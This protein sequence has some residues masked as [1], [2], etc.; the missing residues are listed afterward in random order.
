MTLSGSV[1]GSATGGAWSTPAGGTFTPNA[2]TLTATWTPPAVFTGI[3][4]LTLTTTGMAPCSAVTSTV[5]ITVNPGPTANAGPPQT[6]CQGGSVTLS[7]TIGGSATGGTWTTPVGGTFTPDANTL[8]ATWT[9][10][11]AYSGNAVL[12]LTTMGSG[13]CPPVISTVTITVKIA[14][15]VSAGAPQTI[16][17][18]GSAILVGTVGGSA[19]GGTWST[20]V[21]GVFSPN[22][23]T[24]A[25]TWTPP[26][27]YTGTA[28][29]TLT[30]TGMGPCV[31]INSTVNIT[32]TPAPTANAGAP[33][34]ICQ[35]GN[36]SLSGT[37]GGSASGGTWTTLSGGVF[38]P[39]P[40]TLTATWT[41]PAAFSG[42]A[43]LTLTTT[44]MS[45]C[46]AVTSNVIITVKQTPTAN[47]GGPQNICQGGSA[48]LNG[49][50]GGS[51]TGGF[52]TTIAGGTFTPNANTLT[53]TWTPLPGFSGPATLTL[54]TTGMIPCSA[55]TSD[56]IITVKPTPT[57]NA[58]TAQTICQ[59]GSA[60]LSGLV[61]GSATGGTWSTPVG[62]TFSPNA[63]TLTTTWTPPA[64]YT[65]TATLTL[66]TTGMAPC[67]A[68]L[69]TV[70]ITV[71][72]G[73]TANA[74][75]PQ[76]ICQGGTVTLSGTIGGSATG[77][78]WSTP[79]GGTF[80]PDANTL[81]AT[82]TPP[83][84]YT[85]TAQLT[86]TTTGSGP[87]P[88]VISNVNIIVN[89]VP[90][91]NAQPVP[92]QS[93]CVGGVLPSPLN[94]TFTGG[95]GTPAYQWYSNTTSSTTGGT[96]IPGA[97]SSNYLPP[98][99]GS[100]GSFYFYVVITFSANGCN[101]VTSNSAEVIV[102]PDPT[103]TDPL[104]T[105]TLCQNSI[106]ADLVVSAAGGVGTFSYQW[107]SNTVNNNTTGTIIA[108]AIGVS[109]TP[110]TAAVGTKYYYC[111]ITQT[112]PG[113]GVSSN[114]STVIVNAGPTFTTQ[115]AP[116]AVCVGGTPTLLN[117]AY[118]NGAGI[119][120]YQWYSNTVNSYVG[121]TILAGENNP[122]YAPSSTIAGTT[123]Y[124]CVISFSSGGCSSINSNI[125]QVVIDA[126]PAISTQPIPTQDL[127]VG[128]VLPA[129][130]SVSYTGGTGIASYQW[131]SNT[132]A[133]TT[134]GT[135]IPGATSSTYLPPAFVTAGTYY[136]YVI[137]SLSGS[138][139][140][141]ATSSIA[142]VNVI[143]DPTVTN[144]LN[145]QSLCQNVAPS[146]LLVTASGGVGSYYYQWYSNTVN[147]NTTGTIIAGAITSSY[148]PPTTAVG[149]KYYYCVITQTGSGCGVSSNTATVIVNAGATI[150][151]QPSPSNVCAGGT[152]TLLNVAF[153]NGAG[154]PSFQWYSNSVNSYIGGTTLLG[155]TNANYQPSGTIAG[156]TFYFC[157]ISFSAGGG[158]GS[159]NSNIAQVDV[160][161]IPAVTS[162]PLDSI[163]SRNPFSYTITSDVSNCSFGWHRSV[164][165]GISNPV[166]NGVSA[167]INETLINTTGSD[168]NVIYKLWTNGPAPTLCTSDTLLLLV[169]VKD[170]AVSAGNDT[171]ISFGTRAHLVGLATGG[172]GNLQYSWTP[173]GQILSGQNARLAETINQ[174]SPSTFTLTVTDLNMAGCVLTDNVGVFLNGSALAASPTI[175]PSLVCP[176]GLTQLFSNPSGGSGTYTYSWSSVP[177][178]SPI[179]NSTLADPFVNPIVPTTYTV[180]VNDGFN[181]ASGS[182]SNTI[183]APPV[184]FNVTGGGQYCAGGSGLPI[185]L[186][187]SSLL[188]TYKLK[189]QSGT[190]VATVTGTGS[191]LTFG[192][193]TIAG[194]YTAEATSISS[195][196]CTSSMNGSASISIIP[197]PTAYTVTGGGS[198]PAGG[199]GVDIG[200][201]N[202]QTGVEY[203][204]SNGGPVL[205][206][207]Q[208]TGSAIS[209]G[210]QT[211]AGTYTVTAFTLTNPVCTVA[212]TGSVTVIINPWPTIYNVYGGG[213]VCADD[214][215]GKPVG[216]DGSDVGVTYQLK[217]DGNNIGGPVPGTGDSI[218]FGYFH[219]G[220][221][222]SVT[223]TNVLTGLTR[224][225]NGIATININPIPIAYVMGSYGDNC[226]GSEIMLNGSQTGAN[227][228]LRLNLNP[229]DTMAG[230]GTVLNFG[231][232]WQAG[233]YTIYAY[234]V[235]TGC[236]TIM[237][238]MIHLNPAPNVYNVRP[239]GVSCAGDTL[240]ITGSQIGIIY[241][242]QRDTYTNV[243]SPI[244]GTGFPI[245]FGPQTVA[246]IYS[247][248]AI[249][250]LTNCK[251]F[252]NGTANLN[253]LPGLFT[254]VPN[255][256]TCAGASIGLSGSQLGMK[257]IL[258]RD[259]LWLDTLNGTGSPLE[260]G[261]QTIPGIYTIVGY[262]TTTFKFCSNLMLGTTVLHPGPVL[263]AIIP[264]GFNCVGDSVGLA[265]SDI[266]VSYQ[267]ILNGNQNAGPPVAG[268][269]GPIWFGIQNYPGNYTI[270]GRNTTT[271]CSSIM[272]GTCILTPLPIAYNIIPQGD[273][274]AG[275]SI[276]LN[277]SQVG[278]NYILLRDN[279]PVMTLAGTGGIL[280]FGPQTISGTYIIRAYNVTPD[281]CYSLMTGTTVIYQGPLAY[282]VIPTGISCAGSTVGLSG[283]QIG[284]LYQLFR[285][286]IYNIGVPVPG[287]G[288]AISFGV[289]VQPGLYS[290]K[291][292]SQSSLCFSV[293]TGEATLLTLPSVYT[294]TPTGD[295][296]AHSSIGINGS[297]AGIHY[298]LFRDAIYPVATIN[299]NGGPVSFGLQT[300]SGV[301]TITAYNSTSDSCHASM[302]GSLTIHPNPSIFSIVPSGVVCGGNTV[303]LSFSETGVNYQLFRDNVVVDTLAGTGAFLDFGPQTFNGVYTILAINTI[304]N[305]WSAMTGS[306]TI[307]PSPTA[308]TMIP[309]G[310]TCEQVTIGL[311]GS[312]PGISYILKRDGIP[313]ETVSGTGSPILFTYVTTS[314]TYSITAHNTTSDTCTAGM[315]GSLVIHP[316]PL[317]YN[318]IP[319]GANCE[320][321][322]IGITGS[323]VGVD[324]ELFKNGLTTGTILT[325]TGN[326][327]SFSDQLAG[328]YTVKG[329]YALSPNCHSLMSGSVTVNAPPTV[330]AGA[331]DSV[332]HSATTFQLS[333][334]ASEYTTISWATSGDGFFTN[335]TALNP[336]YTI[337]VLDKDNGLVNLTILVNG[338]PECPG[339]TATDMMT[340]IIDP[341]PIAN[342]GPDYDLCQGQIV[343]L[344]G[345]AQHYSTVQWT[346]TGDGLFSNNAILNPTY[347][348]G[349]GD[350]LA[351]T[352]KLIL[353]ANGSLTCHAEI[354]RDTLS[355]SIF[356]LPTATISESA[357]ICEA[358]TASVVVNLTGTP[359]WSIT[360]TD[361]VK[362]V[363]VSPIG[364]SPFILQVNPSVTT[365][366]SLTALSDDH[367]NGISFTGTAIIFVHP[368]PLVYQVTVTN[369]GSYCEGN[370]GVTIGLDNSQTGIKYTLLLG[371]IQVA[372]SIA[373]TGFPLSFGVF[374]TP[375]LYTVNGID[376]TTVAHCSRQMNG[377]V[378]V[379][380]HPLPVVDFHADTTC[381]GQPT[382]FVL[383]GADIGKIAL[384]NWNFGD[385]TTADYNYP[386]LPSHT[387]PTYGDYQV[388]LHVTD[389]N[390]CQRQIIHNIHVMQLPVSLFA[391]TTPTCFGQPVAFTDYSY[392][393]PSVVTHLQT[394]I[395]IYGDGTTD[396]IHFPASPDVT[397]LYA[398]PG[399][400][401]VTLMVINNFGCMNQHSLPITISPNPVANFF[402]SSNQCADKLVQFTDGSQLNGGGAI[403]G[404]QWNFGDPASGVNNLSNLQNPV[405]VYDQAGSYD[406]K[407]I[408]SSTSACPD[409]IVKTIQVQMKPLALFTANSPCKGNATNFSDQ[410]VPHSM[411]IIAWDWNFG[412]GSPGS[413]LQN[414]THTYTLAGQYNVTLSVTNNNQCTHDTTI[415]VQVIPLPIASY[416]SDAPKCLGSQV[417]Y[418]NLS[419]SQVGQIVKWHW[420]FGD[421][422]DT[423][424]F[425]PGVPNVS[426]VF[427]GTAQQHL[428]RLTVTTSD[429]CTDYYETI[430]Q[431]VP[432]PVASYSYSST[433]CSGQNVQF[434]DL[435]QLNG[436][437][438][439]TGWV[440][441]FDDPTSGIQNISY[442]QNPVHA[443][444]SA[445]TY[446]VILTSSNVS[447]SNTII[448]S[449]PINP[450]P[451]AGFSADTACFGTPTHFQDQSV[452]NSTQIVTWDWNFGD[453]SSHA[454]I[455]NP[456]HLYT[457]PGTY[458]VTL[459]VTNSNGCIQSKTSN[460]LVI[461]SPAA[462]FVY[463]TNNCSGSPVQF[464][465]QSTTPYGYIVKWT[466]NF[467]DGTS[468]TINLPAS[469]NVTH[470]Y[471]AG[472]TYVV[473]LAVKTADSCSALISH[474]IIVTSAPAANFD[475]PTVTCEGTAIQF[476]DLSQQN[477][478]G[479][480]MNWNWDFGDPPSGINNF[481][482]LQNP[483]HQFT[484]GGTHNVQLIVTNIST[485]RDTIIKSLNINAKPSANFTADTVCKGEITQFTDASVANAGTITSWLWSFGDGT[486]SILQNPTHQYAT[487]GSY[488]VLLTVTN[489]AGCIHD[490]THMAQVNTTPS[491]AF[492]YAQLC[493]G[494][495]TQF[496]DMST[497]TG[498]VIGQWQW[499][500]GD[501]GTSTVQNPLHTYVT[502]GIFN[503]RLIVENSSNCSDTIILPVT[504][505]TTPA[506][507]YSYFN[508]YC[509]QGIVSFFDQST[510]TNTSIVSWYWEFEPGFYS[511]AKD[512]IYHFTQTNT[513]YPVTLIVTD[514][515]GC[516]D[517]I[518]DTVF[519]RPAFQLAIEKNDTCLGNPNSFHA[520][521][522][523]AGDLLHNFSWNFGE[524]SSFT[525]TSALKDPEHTYANP[526]TYFVTLKAYNSDN[527]VDSVYKM[528]T[529]FPGSIADFSYN[530]GS[531][532]SDTTVIFTNLSSGNGADLDS[533]IYTF[534]DGTRAVK[535]APF[536]SPDTVAHHYTGFGSYNVSLTAINTNGC[537]SIKTKMVA[538]TCMT[539]AFA[540]ADTIICQNS[541]LVLTDNSTPQSL[542]NKWYWDF[543]DGL[544]TTYFAPCNTFKHKFL[545]PGSY[546]VKLVI[547]TTVSGVT[548]SDSSNQL[549][550]VK[551]SPQ[552]D[553]STLSV[554][555]GDSS[556]FVDLT[557][558]STMSII[559]H[560]WKFG[561]QLSGAN[562]TSTR[563]D[564]AHKYSHYGNFNPKLIVQNAVGCFD[565][566]VKPI[567][568]HKLPV[569]KFTAPDLLCSRAP[570]E[571]TDKS[572]A[573][574]TASFSWFWTL[575]NPIDPGNLSI[576]QNPVAY[577]DQAGSYNIILK[578]RDSFGCRDSVTNTVEILSSPVSSFIAEPNVNGIAGK[579]SLTNTS[580]DAIAY[581]WDFGNGK[582]SRKE[583]PGTQTYEI[584][585]SYTIVLIAWADNQCTD[586]THYT[587]EILFQGLFVPNAFAPLTSDVGTMIFKPKGV[588]LKEYEVQV[589]DT[590]GHLLWESIKLDSEGRPV[591]YWD[592]TD[593][594]GTL[595]PQGTYV[596]KI[597]A[598]FLDGS[599]WQ[600]SDIGKSKGVKKPMGTVTLI[601]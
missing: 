76:T 434:T 565:S 119:A 361:G 532:C 24:L 416:Q 1:G 148:T 469:P 347:T 40:N 278:V 143:P 79:V 127:C 90:A 281:S 493:K 576:E 230:T 199:S 601:R 383:L 186:S 456:I 196:Q 497:S 494:S 42:L 518:V 414:P 227:Y 374:T 176:G 36:V 511:V 373:G 547:S 275:T 495:P 507:Q 86:L 396:T 503:V 551:I 179:W 235:A 357:N 112:G 477:G 540:I 190:T 81:T 339:T 270:I 449:I 123:Y 446:D 309:T 132:I 479:S 409:T 539:T 92:T 96:I 167:S 161:P 7:G 5:S 95:T 15:T 472:G 32:V 277:E 306:T 225:M 447:C 121:G 248:L 582:S 210:L 443:F 243:G 145:S 242:L 322:V 448:K 599:S 513:N 388:V 141:A 457:L 405:H 289:Q 109:Y 111:V 74:G 279:A 546:T 292:T 156:T 453:G 100:P 502:S 436:G 193:F 220:T 442:L 558:S 510:A 166:G 70:N 592:G 552:A 254:I 108:G 544:D 535:T 38:S 430:I 424:V 349:T 410:S 554:C 568:V 174:F 585:G 431:S 177:P 564:P 293:M 429:S 366:Y 579:V 191:P 328:V 114:T 75:S 574:D 372:N 25:A 46:A 97:T 82:W 165:A 480:L 526:G 541:K 157:T 537:R 178:G 559:T 184:S 64:P 475:Y 587:F 62:G 274:C 307:T 319:Q 346:S 298:T 400:Y 567:R 304:T 517:T 72:P 345:S 129:A 432:T 385:G 557:D 213:G 444:T 287:T 263:H 595:M 594:S 531:F 268:T 265:N 115:P 232:Q 483:F 10:P 60:T 359:P 61:G 257:Y 229:V 354:S 101:S 83:P 389:T 106:P 105:Q 397:H 530:P 280:S 509:P 28:V 529:V 188:D 195:P 301:Y 450:Q 224:T 163:C 286:G 562:D 344:N 379:L 589:F 590:W 255:G 21:G 216:I 52:W 144:P 313:V 597:S 311:N 45:P 377:T 152:P 364:T 445:G 269:G 473:T 8:T 258:K 593:K 285:D 252:M 580:T 73:P 428:V 476:T 215:T 488:Q 575:G 63:N 50:V 490:T 228:V 515:N 384:W 54:S 236:D 180:I 437:S 297:Q 394:W 335:G 329:R 411:S 425:F 481:S 56:V 588:G 491:A 466:W 55:V 80:N 471:A 348:A 208:G 478:G 317:S 470:S 600:G 68:A 37:V 273:T 556:K 583:D 326:P 94:V 290:V 237:D 334:S 371:G 65:G 395:W 198:Y 131:Y 197:L 519:V 39:N 9:P 118:T 51:A 171:T 415:T 572:L 550:L 523:A 426:H 125:A 259:T 468:T 351:G 17:Q 134:G 458:A 504:I 386:Y 514:A 337:G 549:I 173:A 533:L 598:T 77:G 399:N 211:V 126:P 408:I 522:L 330:N 300:T 571:F 71:N 187:G 116:S 27:A 417:Y 459:N 485:C 57:S 146:D 500:F 318:V 542:I 260:F 251:I 3:A 376:T 14:P 438:V 553:F 352:F 404:W 98:L 102:S 124:Y 267:L 299:G 226:V 212:M 380:V 534:G 543:G 53:A 249:N 418:S 566:L 433:L 312:Q 205:P 172:V 484:T 130:L 288:V 30:T 331:N 548:I 128:G 246:G 506:A 138:G 67:T 13:P 520:V 209:F 158:C 206:R 104:L 201:S 398:N 308:Y 29:L 435:T 498:G 538:V 6:I 454:S 283:S 358:D 440:W 528:V 44:G 508:T 47:A 155:E 310:D 294:I 441:N 524:S 323:Q 561:D 569:A 122:S 584:N 200:L 501:G 164:V 525:N 87:C 26:P 577:Y 140:G 462:N 18:G 59:G 586:T 327:L 284:I 162:H 338:K 412:D 452:P 137:V 204:L 136:Y 461:P 356:P 333:A 20:L 160:N 387:Y 360:Y 581:L 302:Q 421:G 499:D 189:D 390:G 527:C 256:D 139:C 474:S 241:Q 182:V 303:G 16:C 147:N 489:T 406:V 296:C 492:S 375:G 324:Y 291:A 512:P 465:D 262:D 181:T 69:S 272:T 370:P 536:S 89:P 402:Y 142:Q 214:S 219:V 49:S 43:T 407:L 66:T 207:V 325:G 545:Q 591:D 135:T 455:A 516:K 41:P 78:T 482:T 169:K 378:T 159:V 282:N 218:S 340:L 35:G 464:T 19:T 244:P 239:P 23:N 336:I 276:G 314:G 570:I 233:D 316:L 413:N 596:W 223:G 505:Y 560:S 149:T 460:V 99:F 261:V 451:A 170:F 202:S 420:D 175:N 120:S 332:C 463:S 107:F 183:K 343:Q 245:S 93:L 315:I 271:T 240:S 192:I 392:S 151:T 4:V 573:G 266:G 381:V 103:V 342:A 203:E 12:T 194:N 88:N 217:R 391:F 91:V 486:T 353:T 117:V 11:P 401:S 250:P 320:P 221:I 368:K 578:I 185:G 48:T 422:T 168:I 34:T 234:F 521:N 355:V 382:Q 113:C 496:Q 85:G 367:C 341:L 238:G 305:C 264:M 439:L 321:T 555:V 427:T 350:L 33:Q 84:A 563:I 58:G 362:S 247:V 22:P 467:G 419:T 369:G 365:S 222:Y 363:T 2:S 110:L 253:P 423:T 153:I 231:P 487:S 31:A 403:V 295:T 150:T 133:S 393:I 154:I